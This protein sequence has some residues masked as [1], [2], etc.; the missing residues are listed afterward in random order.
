MTICHICK[1]KMHDKF[2]TLIKCKLCCDGL[3]QDVCNYCS[4]VYYN[5]KKAFH[6]DKADLANLYLKNCKLCGQKE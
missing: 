5:F 4:Q 1:V 2:S 3:E 6:N